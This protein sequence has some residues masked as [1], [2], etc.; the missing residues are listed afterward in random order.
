MPPK[1]MIVN[2]PFE[3]TMNAEPPHE[4]IAGVAFFRA[5]FDKKFSGPLQG[6]SRVQLLGAR[7]P[8]P[9]SAGY[10]ALER[11]T[12]T[13]AGRSGTFALV[14]L[15]LSARGEQSLQ[16]RIVPDS[17]TGGLEG[18]AGT[19]AIEIASGRHSY[20]LDYSLPS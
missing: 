13:L 1:A 9:S 2:G 7:G 19:M 11:I 16:I 18:I 10:V 20:T 17:G 5:T 12:A 8:V 6:T 15:G 4:E 3:V 14:H